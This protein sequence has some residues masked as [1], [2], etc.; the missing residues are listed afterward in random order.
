MCSVTIDKIKTKRG[1]KKIK[2]TIKG[3]IRGVNY[4]K[5]ESSDQEFN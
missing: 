2:K 4:G 3:N 5:D 1:I